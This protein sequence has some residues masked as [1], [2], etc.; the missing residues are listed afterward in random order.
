MN[1]TIAEDRICMGYSEM[2]CEALS[3]Q[4]ENKHFQPLYSI[5]ILQFFSNCLH[6]QNFASKFN[7]QIQ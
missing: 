6:F 7:A 5:I 1:I 2:K 3:L 4:R